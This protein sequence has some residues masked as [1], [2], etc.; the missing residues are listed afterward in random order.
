MS[1]NA[2]LAVLKITG[3]TAPQKAGWHVRQTL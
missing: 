3:L 2:I 1:I